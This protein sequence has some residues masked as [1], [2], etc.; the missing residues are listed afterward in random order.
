MKRMKLGIVALV[1]AVLAITAAVV[2]AQPFGGNDG[3]GRGPGRG[4][5]WQVVADALGIDLTTLQTEL[6]AGKTIVDI[7]AENDVAVSAVIDA[8]VADRQTTLDVAVAA[9][10]LTQA[11]ADAQI[12]LLKANLEVQ[13]SK[14]MV[15]LGGRSGFGMRGAA[16]LTVI[17]EALGIDASTLQTELQAGKTVAD[18]AGE[19]NVE[20]STIVDAVV[21]AYQPTFDAAVTDGKLTQEQA[22]AQVEL[23][24]ANLTE[25][26]SQTWMSGR[27]DGFPMGPGGMGQ[28]GDGRGGR[29]HGGGFPMLPDGSVPA[30]PDATPEATASA[31]A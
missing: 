11:Q 7:A 26:F 17:A 4:T 15:G 12:A 3:N 8:V 28:N 1:I 22:D 23:L 14:S 10:T 20:L 25:R 29:G 16:Q 5:D 31:N 2:G 19:Q 30:S 18:I 21:A 27:G 9:G 13:F 6:Q 24:K